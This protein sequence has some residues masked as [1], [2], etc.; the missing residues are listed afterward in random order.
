VDPDEEEE[1]NEL[2]TKIRYKNVE[3]WRQSMNF[4]KAFWTGNLRK[5]DY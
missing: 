4:F 2:T 3:D 1:V 5:N